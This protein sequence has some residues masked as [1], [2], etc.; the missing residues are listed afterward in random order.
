MSRQ[1]TPRPEPLLSL[2]WKGTDVCADLICACGYHGHYH[3]MF[4]YYVRCAGCGAVFECSPEI[5]LTRVEDD[6]NRSAVLD[7]EPDE[8]I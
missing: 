8:G 5:K 3:G 4:M 1:G 2:Q 7:A 6:P